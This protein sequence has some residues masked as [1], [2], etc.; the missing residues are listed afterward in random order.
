MSKDDQATETE[1]ITASTNA[2]Q[3]E[4]FMQPHVDDD[5]F[6]NNDKVLDEIAAEDDIA[7]EATQMMDADN[8]DAGDP[9][10]TTFG[11]SVES[12]GGRRTL[13]GPNTNS[14]VPLRHPP[15][16]GSGRKRYNAAGEEVLS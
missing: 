10:S 7:I 3:K 11:F 6:G 13:T 16:S 2:V 1:Q 14:D 15:P 4:T 5:T 12:P 9:N 8:K